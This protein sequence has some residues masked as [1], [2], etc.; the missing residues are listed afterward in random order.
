MLFLNFVENAFKYAANKNHDKSKIDILISI[1]GPILSFSCVNDFDLSEHQENRLGVGISNARR[2]L[3]LIYP[4]RHEL[5]IEKKDDKY[6]VFLEIQL[7]E[8]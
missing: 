5:L 4:N 7:D 6:S 2:R 1:D 3:E 8:N